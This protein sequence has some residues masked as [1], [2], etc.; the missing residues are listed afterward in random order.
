MAEATAGHR[1]PSSRRGE[2]N[3]TCG[4]DVLATAAWGWQEL[5]PPGE[6][7]GH[8]VRVG[9]GSRVTEGLRGPGHEHRLVAR[10]G[11]IYV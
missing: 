5:A 6:E 3:R 4:A 1:P 9:F 7:Q 8:F 2:S 11:G 10:C